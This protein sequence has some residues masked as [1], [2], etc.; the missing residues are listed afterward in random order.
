MLPDSAFGR[1]ILKIVGGTAMAQ[2]IAI[3]ASPLLT[4]IYDPGAFGIF[5]ALVGLASMLTIISS[6]SYEVAIPVQRRHMIAV[7]LIFLCIVLLLGN[8][9]ITTL[10]LLVFAPTIAGW[11]FNDANSPIW[12]LAIPL[13]MASL[14]FNQI[15]SAAALRA[16]TFNVISGVKVVQTATTAA[17]QA[18]LFSVGPIGLAVGM[19]A[20]QITGARRLWRAALPRNAIKCVSWRNIVRTMICFR[21]FPLFQGPFSLVNSAGNFLPPVLLVV[22]FG[23]TV[24]GLFAL[25]QRVLSAPVGML[26]SASGEVFFAS[27]AQANREGTL[28]ALVVRVHN[29]VSRLVLP[30]FVLL[31]LTGPYVFCLI[32]GES[33]REAGLVATLMTPWLYMQALGSTVS[34]VWVVQNNLHHGTIIGFFGFILRCAAIFSAIWIKDWVLVIGIFSAVNA[35]YYLFVTLYAIRFSGASLSAFARIQGRALVVA[36]AYALPAAAGVIAGGT[37]E[38][39]AGLVVSCIL[40]I[41]Y[42]QRVVKSL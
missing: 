28:G 18:A 16:R 14:G 4:R 19:I 29:N 31:A 6:L 9:I 41:P 42:Y 22:F 40:L 24:G 15:A 12:V 36:V 8:V 30:A 35:L 2:G 38:V 26:A 1:S 20:G 11:L 32:F 37:L 21:R 7:N 17:F 25:A 23:P 3:A 13:L 27:A 39:M 10:V 33:W 34:S 5:A